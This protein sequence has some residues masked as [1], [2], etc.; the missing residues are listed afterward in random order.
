MRIVHIINGLADGGAERNLF[1][2]CANDEK[3]QHSVIALK[4]GGKYLDPLLESGVDYGCINFNHLRDMMSVL[5]RLV[6]TL[7]VMEPDV[8]QTWMPHSDLLGSIAGFILGRKVVW[9]LRHGTYDRRSSKLTTRIVVRLLGLLSSRIPESIISCSFAG[10]EAHQNAGYDRLKIKVIPNGIDPRRFQLL[11]ANHRSS[12]AD[13][14]PVRIGILARF[15]PQKDHNTF[16]KAMRLFLNEFPTALGC[17]AGIVEDAERVHLVELSKKFGVSGHINVIGPVQDPFCFYQDIDALVMCSNGGEGFPNV[18][19][20]AMAC[21]LP[22]V[23]TDVGDAKYMQGGLG[24][25]VSPESPQEIANALTEIFTNP[26]H[27]SPEQMA[28]RRHHV[29]EN[30]SVRQMVSGYQL[31]YSRLHSAGISK[32]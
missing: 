1:L 16:L 4:P 14:P 23:A 32:L 12:D 17:V 27:F 21:G 7:N 18:V 5:P 6:R 22:V 13:H 10:A 11:S 9:T 20:E 29:L 19:A 8:I 26:I 28:I 30:F 2:L 25:V 31:E 3:N 24:W 15:H